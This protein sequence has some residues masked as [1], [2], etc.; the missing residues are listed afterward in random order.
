VFSTCVAAVICRPVLN[1]YVAISFKSS[2][3]M[4]YLL[5]TFVKRVPLILGSSVAW[6]LSLPLMNSSNKTEAAYFPC[7]LCILRA[8]HFISLLC[9]CFTRSLKL[10]HGLLNSTICC[11]CHSCF[12][13]LAYLLIMMVLLMNNSSK[14]TTVLAL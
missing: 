8:F 6:H 14:E 2:G 5:F 9:F 12:Y 1:H 10:K 11:F 3:I 7:R 4:D 13:Q